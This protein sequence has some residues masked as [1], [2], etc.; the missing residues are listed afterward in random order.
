MFP[1]TLLPLSQVLAGQQLAKWDPAGEA[2]EERL[3][4]LDVFGGGRA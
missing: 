3:D 2:R 4:M 1:W